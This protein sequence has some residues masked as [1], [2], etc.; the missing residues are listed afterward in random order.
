MLVFGHRRRSTRDNAGV[1]GE[2]RERGNGLKI[3]RQSNSVVCASTGMQWIVQ[4]LP[5]PT[6]IYHHAREDAGS[7]AYV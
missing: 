1:V 4:Y 2:A 7:S 3:A 6:N 5:H